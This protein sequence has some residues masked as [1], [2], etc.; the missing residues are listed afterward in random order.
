LFNKVIYVVED[1]R[2]L[3]KDLTKQDHVVIER[4]ARNSLDIKQY[5]SID[6]GL[7]FIAER[8]SNTNVGFVNLYIK[9]GKLWM[10][11]MVRSV[12]L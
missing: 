6:K 7:N 4:G 2:K 5:Y 10:N 11:R 12:N 9:Y 1:V 8:T 3:S